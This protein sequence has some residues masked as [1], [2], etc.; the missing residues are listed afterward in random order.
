M[1]LS[2]TLAQNAPQMVNLPPNVVPVLAGFEALPNANQTLNIGTDTAGFAFLAR[3]YDPQGS[4][5]AGMAGEALRGVSLTVGPGSGQ[6]VVE[7]GSASTNVQGTVQIGIGAGG[8]IVAPAAT[9]TPQAPLATP[10]SSVCRATGSLNV[11]V[12]TGPGTDYPAFGTLSTGTSL[13]VV[14]RNNDSSWYVVDYN[15]RQG[16]VSNSVVL[17]DGPCS[18]LPFVTAPPPPATPTPLPTSTPSGPTVDFRSTVG[19]GVTYP[20]GTCASPSTG[21]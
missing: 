20:A 9:A 13:N 10:T 15:G 7:I 11:N 4:L 21:P 18:A 1:S 12:R 2:T 3:V 16:W 14:G 19:D 8:S 6:Y 5:I 17:L